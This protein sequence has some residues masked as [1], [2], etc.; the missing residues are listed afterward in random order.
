MPYWVAGSVVHSGPDPGSRARSNYPQEYRNNESKGADTRPIFQPWET[1]HA[2]GKLV[3]YIAPSTDTKSFND[4]KKAHSLK[5]VQKPVHRNDRERVARNPVNDAGSLR[6]VVAQD[7]SRVLGAIYH[8]E[9]SPAGFERAPLEPL[10]RQSRQ[11]AAQRRH[12]ELVSH[13]TFP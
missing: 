5:Q 3:E 9:S 11:H 6:A 8:P 1:Q 10:T 12:R 2:P 4:N 13:S 7:R